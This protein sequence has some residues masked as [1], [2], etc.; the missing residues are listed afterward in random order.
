MARR[1][2]A[3]RPHPGCVSAA[4]VATGGARRVA[5]GTFG[6]IARS[7]PPGTGAT[8]GWSRP[9]RACRVRGARAVGGVGRSGEGEGPVHRRAGSAGRGRAV[10]CGR[11]RPPALAPGFAALVGW[12]PG[13]RARR[14][15]G[16]RETGG[17]PE[18]WGDPGSEPRAGPGASRATLELRERRR[19][20]AEEAEWESQ[21]VAA[22]A[23]C[24]RPHR[25]STRSGDAG[26]CRPERASDLPVPIGRGEGDGGSRGLAERPSGAA[27][28]GRGSTRP[29]SPVRRAPPGAAV[30]RATAIDRRCG[31]DAFG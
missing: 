20:G 15:P 30:R 2:A 23:R 10:P 22:P 6:P 13:R 29:A 26:R 19:V 18:E 28:G 9:H 17:R 31:R 5:V 1:A 4:G 21:D 3:R 25:A 8:V 11:G 12:R 14:G 16:L 27:L 7:G 24:R